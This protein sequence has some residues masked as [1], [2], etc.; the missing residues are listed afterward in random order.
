MTPI[1]T[2]TDLSSEMFAFIIIIA[3]WSSVW[4]AWAL[5]RAARNNALV[6]YIVMLIINTAGI[7]EIVYIF[8]FSNYGKKKN[9]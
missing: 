3:I 2:S 8:G 7:L 9:G 5:W 4:K 1:T 6:W